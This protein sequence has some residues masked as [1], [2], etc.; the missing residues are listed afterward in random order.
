MFCQT[1]IPLRLLLCA[2]LPLEHPRRRGLPFR[3]VEAAR[4][5]VA[6]DAHGD[7]IDERRFVPDAT[8]NPARRYPRN[9]T[10]GRTSAA[11]ARS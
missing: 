10:V 3:P 6:L 8:W 7:R 5:L 9:R 4:A 11:I 2:T 1:K